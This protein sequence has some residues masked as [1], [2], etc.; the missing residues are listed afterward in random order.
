MRLDL[1]VG[2]QPAEIAGTAPG[3]AL[4]PA[5]DVV[6]DRGFDLPAGP[7]QVWPWIAQLGKGRAGWYLPRWME[8]FVPRR[9]RALRRSETSWQHLRP[10]DVT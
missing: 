2:A 10:G 5:P 8:R 3:D 9:R 6:V 7:E 1:G 4:V